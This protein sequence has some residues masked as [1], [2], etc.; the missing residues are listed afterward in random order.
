MDCHWSTMNF[1]NETPDDRFSDTAFTSKYIGD[2]YY[3]IAQP[4]AYGDRIFLIDANGAAIH[5]GVFIAD[6]IIFTKNGNNYAQPWML[7]RLKD[8]L[9]RY[10][11]SDVA[12][13]VVVYRNKDE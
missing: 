10:G 9:A 8:L 7:M 11:T 2:H 5:S 13:R 12:P 1:F 3:Q 4:S 6:D